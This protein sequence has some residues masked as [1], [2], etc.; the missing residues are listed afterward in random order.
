MEFSHLVTA[1]QAAREPL[2]LFTQLRVSSQSVTGCKTAPGSM[3]EAFEKGHGRR[4][5]AI[6]LALLLVLPSKA[7][8]LMRRKGVFRSSRYGYRVAHVRE[9]VLSLIQGS[10]I[11]NLSPE[12]I[13][14]LRSIEALMSMTADVRTL[15]DSLVLRLR[16]RKDVVVKT[17]LARLDA[18]FKTPH[19]ADISENSDS[20]AYYS[21]EE[22][23]EATSLLL[24][25]F[26]KG[27]GIDVQQLSGVDEQALS[28]AFY[29][30]L[31]VDAAKL[32]EFHTSEVLVDAFPYQASKAL[33]L[34]KSMDANYLPGWCGPVPRN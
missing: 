5:L 3:I 8:G 1:L 28:G 11:C 33:K 29:D 19:P 2:I 9:V 12:S 24:H 26:S 30:D 15:H 32:S 34:A 13:S 23:A 18:L 21:V 6:G 7:I 4:A 10:A 31:L 25:L 20:I 16:S 14:Y 17:L 27:I 22:I